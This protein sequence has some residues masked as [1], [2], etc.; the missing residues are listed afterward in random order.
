MLPTSRPRFALIGFTP[1]VVNCQCMRLWLCMINLVHME[2]NW[3]SKVL[4]FEEACEA[5][6]VAGLVIAERIDETVRKRWADQVSW[7]E[8]WHR[9]QDI[10]PS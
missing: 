5:V 7:N 1:G 4:N 8:I 10:D 9:D 3:L 2:L 6:H